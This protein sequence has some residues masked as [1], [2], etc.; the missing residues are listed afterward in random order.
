MLAVSPAIVSFFCSICLS[1][2]SFTAFRRLYTSSVEK[3]GDTASVGDFASSR[4][5]TLVSGDS[6]FSFLALDFL[7]LDF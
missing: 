6:D 3:E 7:D 5:P 4:V 2:T 1:V